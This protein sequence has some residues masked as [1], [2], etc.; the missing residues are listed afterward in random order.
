[1]TTS[2]EQD[3]AD[4]RTRPA[5]EYFGRYFA[6]LNTHDLR[7]VDELFTEDVEFHDDAWPQVIHGRAEMKHFLQCLWTAMPDLRFDLVDGPYLSD[8]AG[9]YAVRVRTSGTMTGPLDPP[10]LPP[11]GGPVA[12]EFAGFYAVRDQQVCQARLMT[13]TLTLAGQMGAVPPPA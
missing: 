9:R 4:P 6:L 5:A 1:M 7:H 12:V 2:N 11:T 10:G 13:D 8:S 3:H